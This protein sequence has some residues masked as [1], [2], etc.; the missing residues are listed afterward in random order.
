[1]RTVFDANMV[2]IV[3]ALLVGLLI[4]WWMFRRARAGS[5]K[6]L[7]ERRNEDPLEAPPLAP[8]IEEDRPIRSGVDGGEPN[9]LVSSGAAAASDVAGQ[10]L[11]VQVHDELPGADGPPDNLEIMKGV[12]PKLVARLHENGIVRFEQIA[13]LSDN[14]VSILDEKMGPF[15]GR[16]RRDRIVEQANYLARGDKDGFEAQFG[17]LGSGL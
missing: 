15:K 4:G 17:K 8:R 11:G 14:E 7:G 16:L 3:I 10:V 13:R 6:D 2:P 9:G 5:A 12:G 1:M